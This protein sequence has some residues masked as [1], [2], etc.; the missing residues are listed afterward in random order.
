MNRVWQPQL[1][2]IILLLW[3]LF[4]FNPYGYYILLRLVCFGVFA[5]LAF[6][7]KNRGS[8]SWTWLLGLLAL[9]Y[10]PFVRVHLS[11]ELW[12]AV[13]IGTIIVTAVSVFGLP[14]DQSVEAPPSQS[15]AA[16]G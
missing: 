3:A 1:V 10:N 7:A 13:N 12:S 14:R 6:E 5:Y 9:L 11:R 4:P 2:A 8:D 16:N 15:G